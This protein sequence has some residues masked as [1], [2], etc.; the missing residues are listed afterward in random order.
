M[1]KLMSFFAMVLLTVVTISCSKDPFVGKW[2]PDNDDSGQTITK[3][4]SDGTAEIE[5][6]ADD[7]VARIAGTWTRVEGEE[8]TITIVF[9]SSTSEAVAP[10][11]FTKALMENL[12]EAISGETT[13][14]VLSEDGERLKS[15]NPNSVGYMVR[16]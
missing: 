2:V 14:F 13:T 1:N 4:N 10:N 12:I 7:A 8:N 16:Y 6:N 5:V 3:I 9:D 11:P 15:L